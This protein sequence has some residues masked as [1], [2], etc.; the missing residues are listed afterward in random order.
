MQ[1]RTKIAAAAIV[2][3]TLA[4]TPSSAQVRSYYGSPWYGYGSGYG[5]SPVYGYGYARAY[6]ASPYGGGYVWG[7]PSHPGIYGGGF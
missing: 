4:A 1:T 2:L 3:A 6:A 7:P 5:Y